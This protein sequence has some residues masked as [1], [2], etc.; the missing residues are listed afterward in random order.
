MAKFNKAIFASDLTQE[1]ALRIWDYDAESGSL[2][3]KIKPCAG[4]RKG[5]RAG[6]IHSGKRSGDYIRVGYRGNVWYAHRLI[7]LMTSGSWPDYQI[8]HINGNGLDNRLD[9]LR[10]VNASGNLRNRGVMKNNTS[11]VTGVAKCRASG[12]WIASIRINKKLETIISTSSF[13]EAYLYRKMAERMNGFDMS[14]NRDQFYC[15]KGVVSV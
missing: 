4:I 3:W 6:F 12:K 7:W 10:A 13:N 15:Y 14:R 2:T 11:G 9:N 1:D 8:D 5:V